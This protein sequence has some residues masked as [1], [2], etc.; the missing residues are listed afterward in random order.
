[1]Y[2]DGGSLYLRVAEAGSRQWIFR[3][4]TNGRLR[5]MG[6]GP[7]HTL[8]LAEA[9]ERATEARKLRLDGIDPIHH[10]RA[11]MAALRAADARTITFRECCEAYLR[12]HDASWSNARHRRRAINPGAIVS[13]PGRL[14]RAGNRHAVGAQGDQAN[15]EEDPGHRVASPW[16]AGSSVGL[17]NGPSL[18]LR[19]QPSE[20]GRPSGACST[21]AEQGGEGRQS[22][23]LPYSDIPEFM[24]KVRADTGVTARALGVHLPDCCPIGRGGGGKVGTKSI[25]MHDCGRCRRRE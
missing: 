18:S 16:Q 14:A 5:D 7:A 11:R 24:A 25:S 8:T 22:S 21:G 17:G 13:N 19:R 6:L 12:S 20:V 4:V 23:A 10:K 1:M 15:L 9:R 3:Y 2:A